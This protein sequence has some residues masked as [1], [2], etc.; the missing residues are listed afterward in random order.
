MGCFQSKSRKQF[1]GHEDPV[2][3]ASQTA[4]KPLAITWN[5]GMFFRYF[6]LSSFTWWLSWS[7][8]HVY[9]VSVSEVEALFELYKSIS[10]SVID[11][12]LIN[13]VLLSFA[14]HN[15]CI[16][17]CYVHNK[18]L[19]KLIALFLSSYLWI[20]VKICRRSY[21]WL[22]LRTGR[23]K[24]SLR[25]GYD[26][27]DLFSFYIYLRWICSFWFPVTFEVVLL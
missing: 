2:L 18:L 1:P 19:R 23:K 15:C 21:N 11:D 6:S 22:Y 8:I 14:L 13:K 24:T 10:S 20:C 7:S 17:H 9:A 16:N 4:C 3:L 25:I 5:K 27:Q 26:S 12:G